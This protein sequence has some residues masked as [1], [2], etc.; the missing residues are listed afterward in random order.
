MVEYRSSFSP[1]IREMLDF[2][3]GVFD[4]RGRMVAHSE[5][6][7]AQL[8]L[9]QFALQA[10]LAKWGDDIAPGD[11]IITNHPYMGGTHT[12]DLQVFQPAYVDDAWIGWTGSIAHHIDIG[13]QFP[14]TES[15]QTTELFQEGLD[16]PGHQARRA[17]AARARHLRPRG[18]QRARPE[19]DAGRS[20]R[21]ARGLPSRRRAT[22]RAV[23]APRH[24]YRGRRDARPAGA[25][26][27]S[28]PRAVRIVARTPRRGRGLPGRRRLRG[29]A[30]GA[31]QPRARA[32]ATASCTSTSRA[33]RIRCAR[34]STC[35]SRART[36]RCTSLSAASP[37]ARGSCRTTGSR[38][39]CTCTSRRAACSTRASRRRCR[40][41]PGRAAHRRP[42]GRGALGAAARERDRREPRLL[43]RLRLPGRR[44][45][46]GTSHA[47]R[48]HHR[49]RR[50]CPAARPMA[51]TRSTPTRRTARSCRPRSPSSSTRSGWSAASSSTAPAAR[52][53]GAAV[54]ASAAT[55]ACSQTPAMACTTSSSTTRGS[56]PQVARAAA[57]ARP[58]SVRLQRDGVWRDLPEQ[59]LP[60]APARRRRELRQ[61]GWRRVRR[62]PSASADG[63]H[64]RL[65]GEEVRVVEARV[66]HAAGLAA[67][68]VQH[69]RVELH[70][71]RGHRRPLLGGS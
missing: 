56:P 21:A 55:T 26:S 8:G 29:H 12:P 47:A 67:R 41:P 19:L 34:A 38:E 17:R 1:I 40:P 62:D 3:C 43:S 59:G 69:A 66:G 5:Q 7:P 49:R 58:S 51:S 33:P 63:R 64:R 30:A 4:E 13:G 20:R 14:G 44:P 36:P 16:L 25:D 52:V 71:Q 2:N 50:R 37:G 24:E 65:L 57:A 6:I 18:R 70:D 35:R 23:R 61:R 31:H 53:A 27:R 48:G 9:M 15:A 42:H 68:E 11:A 28:R 39:S 10:A 45:A 54:S 32:C 46:Y 22:R 60:H